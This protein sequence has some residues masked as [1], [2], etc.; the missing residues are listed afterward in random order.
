MNNIKNP[1]PASN[2]ATY[3]ARIWS[4]TTTT[5]CAE[6]S[7]ID[8]GGLA[9]NVQPSTTVTAKVQETLNFCTYSTGTCASPTSTNVNLGILSTSQIT[10]GLSY[11]EADTNASA[12]Y[13]IQYFGTTLTSGANTI[14]AK[15][16]TASAMVAGTAGFGLNLATPNTGNANFKTSAGAAWSGSAG[17]VGGSGAV[18]AQSTSYSTTDSFAYAPA[19]PAVLSNPG[20]TR[21]SQTVAFAGAPT[22]KTTYTITYAAAISGLTVPGVY[23][24]TIG[25]VCTGVF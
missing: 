9:W 2:G 8:Y 1:G 21:N 17:P 22:A 7:A 11:M 6:N 13:S 20:T 3:Y 23:T 4:C 14:V 19:T 25:Y 16:S 15:G 10:G 24:A 18:N 5:L 12:G